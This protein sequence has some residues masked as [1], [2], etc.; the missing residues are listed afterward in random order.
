MDPPSNIETTCPKCE[1]ETMHQVLRGRLGKGKGGDLVLDATV[2]CT[3]CS[4]VHH[5]NI[6]QKK[7]IAVQ[8]IISDGEKSER[9][10]L[11]VPGEEEVEVDD[12]IEIDELIVKITSIESGGRRVKRARASDIGTIWTKR[13][14]TVPVKVSLYEGR[15]TQPETVECDPDQEFTVGAIIQIKGKPAVIENIKTEAQVVRKG[16][17]LARDIQRVYAR[18]VK[19]RPGP[20]E[21][22]RVR[23]PYGGRPER[24]RPSRR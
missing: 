8:V 10:V 22:R 6:R 17:V 12:E 23:R 14:D 3:I 5:I 9:C 19:G 16:S 15:F 24:R 2:K 20:D 1:K 21:R 18:L 13:F 7:P 11:E 4:E